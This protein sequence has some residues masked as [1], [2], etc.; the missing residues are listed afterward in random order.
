MIC[1]NY[2]G[3]NTGPQRVNG[4]CEE[5]FFGGQEKVKVNVTEFHFLC[6]QTRQ[7]VW[8]TAVGRYTAT[9]C[10]SSNRLKYPHYTVYFK[11]GKSKDT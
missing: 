7:L 8:K 3:K 1:D 2:R 4:F 6:W 9:H 10:S 11:T 5:E